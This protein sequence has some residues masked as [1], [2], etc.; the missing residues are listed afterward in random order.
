[1]KERCPYCG[2]PHKHLP[3]SCME[4]VQMW[5]RRWCGISS[6]HLPECKLDQMRRY[7][8]RM[9]L[10]AQERGERLRIP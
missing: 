10:D 1:M 5:H 2:Q 3:R 6:K 4:R 9:R 7:V 8:A